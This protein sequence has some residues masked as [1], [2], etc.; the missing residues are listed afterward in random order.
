M[1]FHTDATHSWVLGGSIS[2]GVWFGFVGGKFLLE[3]LL[4]VA[5]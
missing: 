5:S 2:V 3:V 4:V 1:Y